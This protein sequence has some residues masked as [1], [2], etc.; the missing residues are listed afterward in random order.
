MVGIAEPERVWHQGRTRTMRSLVTVMFAALVWVGCD[1]GKSSSSTGPVLARWRSAGAGILAG[2]TNLPVLRGVLT[3]PESAGLGDRLATNLTQLLL[4]R[5]AANVPASTLL[6][7]VRAV[8]DGESA[9]EITTE[10]WVVA[11]RALGMETGPLT[12]AIAGW[13][14]GAV[15]TVTNGWWIAASGPGRLSRAGELP[16]ATPTGLFTGEL[17]LPGLLGADAAGWPRVAVTVG[18]SNAVVRTDAVL[19]FA[20]APLGELEAW[21]VPD[22][23]I[24]DP[25][26]RFSVARGIGPLV[27]RVGW[28]K[29]LCGGVAPGQVTAWAQ[30]E[31]TFRNWFAIPVADAPAR[32][33]EIHRGLQPYFGTTNEPGE[34]MGRLIVNSNRSAVAVFDLK[35]CFPTISTLQQGEQSFLMAGFTPGLRSS[36]AIPAE[37]RARIERPE[38]AWY[39]WEI[40][41]ESARNWNV[42]A[43][44]HQLTRRASPNPLNARG[45]KWLIAAAPRLGNSVTELSRIT[46]T[47]YELHRKSDLGLNGLELVLLTRWLDGDAEIARPMPAIPVVKP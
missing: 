44:F 2:Q 10:G 39:E 5:T 4:E 28:L 21:K 7:V 15:A 9:G 18:M 32:I 46:P 42:L 14:R 38:I 6:P 17:D 16:A 34:Y 25:L 8:V 35:A 37:L 36:N 20:R 27:E 3:L 24:R 29:M 1:S 19:D 26:I 43:Q 41:G 33:T 11:V 23:F 47:R 22:G 30:P 13:G 45:L 31:V 12:A 40:T